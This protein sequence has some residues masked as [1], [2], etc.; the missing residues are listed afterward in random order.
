[1]LINGMAA[2]FAIAWFSVLPPE[3][4]MPPAPLVSAEES[5]RMAWCT[6]ATQRSIRFFPHPYTKGELEA[7]IADPPSYMLLLDQEEWLTGAYLDSH[8]HNAR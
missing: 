6:A 4:V 2:C 7:C 8:R 5:V 1:M 3:L